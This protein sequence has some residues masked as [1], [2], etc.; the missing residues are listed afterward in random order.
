MNEH[1][2]MRLFWAAGLILTACQ[3]VQGHVLEKN[4]DENELQKETTVGVAIPSGCQTIAVSVPQNKK[5]ISVSYQE[6]TM[7]QDGTPMQKLAYTTIYVSSA[8]SP[9]KAIRVWTNNA[10][11]GALVKINNIAVPDGEVKLCFT[12]SNW[13][14]K[15]TLPASPAM[16]VQ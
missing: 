4:A 3:A 14:R 12:Y 10:H 5:S 16:A 8:N 13:D 7:N 11:G 6:P 1:V 9:T 15:E 2:A